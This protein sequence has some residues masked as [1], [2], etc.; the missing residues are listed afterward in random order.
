MHRGG[1]ALEIFRRLNLRLAK[2]IIGQRVD[3][4]V[5][6]G[7][8]PAGQLAVDDCGPDGAGKGNVTRHETLDAA[9]A[10]VDE[11]QVDIQTMLF[12]ESC[13]LGHPIRGG[14]GRGIGYVGE[15]ALRFGH[16]RRS[17]SKSQVAKYNRDATA[18]SY[19]KPSTR[20]LP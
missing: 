2:Y 17:A 20:E 18:I 19:H 1:P 16:P 14:R 3:Q 12:K 15:V 7:D 13:V 8:V 11:N 6:D 5:D 9:A 10:A 4:T